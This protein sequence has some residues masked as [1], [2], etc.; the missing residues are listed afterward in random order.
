MIKKYILTVIIVLFFT[1]FQSQTASA[2]DLPTG[3]EIILP[4]ADVGGEEKYLICIPP[5]W[6]GDLLLYAHGYVAFNQPVDLPWNQI[7]LPDGTSLPGVI[8]SAGFGFATTSYSVNGLAIKE[9][10]QEM[11][12]LANYFDGVN[13]PLPNLVLLAGP[14][15]GGLITALAIERYPDV[16][17]GG[18]SSCGPVGDFQG[19]IDYWGD[20]RVVFDYFYPGLL[21]PTPVEIP[22][23]VIENWVSKYAPRILNKVQ[24]KP[25]KLAQLFNV[26]KAPFDPADP[27]TILQTIERLLWYNVFAT[28]DG[29]EKLGGQPFDNQGR[30][31]AGSLRDAK[32]NRKVQRFSGD[33]SAWVEIET[34]YETT[35]V[36]DVP[37]ILMHTTGDEVVPYW[38][39]V[40]YAKKLLVNANAPFLPLEIE[41]YG[42]CNFTEVEVLSGF[43]LLYLMVQGHHSD[44][45]LAALPDL[46]SVNTYMDIAQRYGIYP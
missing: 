25:E 6:N 12:A 16:F 32:L 24:D 9:G 3:C 37:L 20:F 34:N 7:I 38:H 5:N 21:R 33:Q 11:V 19:Q 13:Y 42:H 10:V 44:G 8:M 30:I 36:I 17:D 27:S 45:I 1:I 15:E 41:R 2:Q 18:L 22:E 23:K 35:G 39:Q 28:N 4:H 14:S 26:T 46:E 29:V 43:A 40:L 31:Y